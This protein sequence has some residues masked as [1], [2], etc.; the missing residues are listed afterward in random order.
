MPENDDRENTAPKVR[1]AEEREQPKYEYQRP[2]TGFGAL[3]AGAKTSQ[4]REVEEALRN[5]ALTPA[6]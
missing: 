2:H 5:F 6:A 3:S 4:D 1:F